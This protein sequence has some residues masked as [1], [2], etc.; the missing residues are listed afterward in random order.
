VERLWHNKAI[1]TCPFL[2]TRVEGYRLQVICPRS[3]FVAYRQSFFPV[4]P[5][6]LA[7]ENYTPKDKPRHLIKDGR[8]LLIEKRHELR[9]ICQELVSEGYPYCLA[10]I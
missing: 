5:V 9:Q 4:C 8:F 1:L 6:P 2:E 10:F 3:F 7:I